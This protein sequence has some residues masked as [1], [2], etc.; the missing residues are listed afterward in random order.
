MSQDGHDPV[1][2]LIPSRIAEENFWAKAAVRSTAFKHNADHGNRGTLHY[3]TGTR[4]DAKAVKFQRG[5]SQGRPEP[6]LM[7]EENNDLDIKR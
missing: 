6:A 3:P 4:D 1:L 2:A 5:Y 7:T